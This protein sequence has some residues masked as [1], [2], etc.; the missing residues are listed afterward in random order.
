MRAIHTKGDA[1]TRIIHFSAQRPLWQGGTPPRW[2]AACSSTGQYY[3]GIDATTLGPQGLKAALH[4][5]IDD[6]TVVSYGNAWDALSVLDRSP[7]DATMVQMIYS[8]LLHDAA[9]AR[10]ISTGWNR[11]HA[12]P[13]SYGIGSSGPDYSDLH[14]LYACDWNVNSARSNRFF[15]DCTSSQCTSPAHVEASATT[16]KDTQR[17]QPPASVRGD[18]ARAMFYMAV[19]YDGSEPS[20]S[21]LELGEIPDVASSTMGVLSTLLTWPCCCD[22]TAV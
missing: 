2:M 18:L 5:L 12:W 14:A 17:F 13:R 8:D 1:F 9:S 10:G 16:A 15:D 6:H 19:R 7:S 4:N 20:T 21:D 11:E 22:M 3:S